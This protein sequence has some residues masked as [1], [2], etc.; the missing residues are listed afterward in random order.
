VLPY[1]ILPHFRSDHPESALIDKSLE[2]MVDHHMPF[3]ALRDGQALVVDGDD[4][5]IVG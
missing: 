5:E 1:A 2:H 3:I 4:Q